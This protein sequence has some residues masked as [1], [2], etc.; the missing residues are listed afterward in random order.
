MKR[1]S[2]LIYEHS[3][4]ETPLYEVSVDG[5][6]FATLDFAETK[7][8][9]FHPAASEMTDAEQMRILNKAWEGFLCMGK[10][11][12]HEFQLPDPTP[13]TE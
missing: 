8:V 13:A 3:V 11:T 7:S 6:P 2:L 12:E 10:A 4:L 1:I 9:Q 5:R